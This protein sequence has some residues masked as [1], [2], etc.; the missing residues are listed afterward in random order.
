MSN[1]P[2]TSA[3]VRK[4]PNDKK[5]FEEDQNKKEEEV[6]EV[7]RSDSRKRKLDVEP[8]LMSPSLKHHFYYFCLNCED[9]QP[10]SKFP[11]TLDIASHIMEKGH[12]DFQPISDAIPDRGHVFVENI[13][14][15]PNLNKKVCTL[16]IVTN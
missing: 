10:G 12:A 1:H 3:E 7:G 2:L 16:H 9:E 11:I 4:V 13:T 15:S 6:V 5:G 14:Y 8:L